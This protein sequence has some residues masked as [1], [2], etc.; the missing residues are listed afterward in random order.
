[1]T[2]IF[3]GLMDVS[4]DFSDIRYQYSVS[5]VCRHTAKVYIAHDSFYGS[6]L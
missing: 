3:N 5:F 6:L 4:Y 2:C 1:M